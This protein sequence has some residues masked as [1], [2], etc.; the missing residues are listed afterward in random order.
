MRSTSHSIESLAQEMVGNWQKFDSFCWHRQYDL[1]SPEDWTIVYTHGRDSGLV[2]QSNAHAIQTAMRPFLDTED[3]DV[4]EEHHGHWGCG[5]IDGYAIRVFRNEE[6]TPA[7]QA[8]ANLHFC[9]QDYPLLDEEDYSHREYEATIENMSRECSLSRLDDEFTLPDGWESEVFSWLWD[10]NQRA[11]AS[12]DDAGG[13]PSKDDLAD[14]FT[15]LGYPNL[16][17]D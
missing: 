2:A 7:F 9:M 6:I 17:G 11:V 12:R 5:W 4:I 3:P 10:H 8:W 13:Y 1:E 15:A 16:T 14:A